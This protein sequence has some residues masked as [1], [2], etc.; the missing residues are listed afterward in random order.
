MSISW[1]FLMVG[2]LIGVIVGSTGV[3]AL[4]QHFV[5]APKKIVVFAG[6]ASA[7]VLEE[8]AEVF[9]TLY[10]IKVEL[11]L[12]GSGSILSAMKIART[13]DLFIPGS[14]EFLIEAAKSGVVNMSTGHPKILVYLVPAIIVQ[15]GNPKNITSLEDLARLGLR[16]GIGDPQSVCVGIYAKELLEKASLWENVSKNIVVY[17]QSC[18]ATAALIPTKAVDAIVGWHVFQ[19]WTPDK[20]DIVWIL[21]RKIPKIGYIAGAVSNFAQDKPSAEAFLD[22]L[23]SKDAQEIWTKYGYFATEEDARVHAP[24]SKIEPL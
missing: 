6:A 7:P 19:S 20:A 12:G 3:F 9:E 10:Q 2:I 14:P 17:A 22:F 5:S 1:K 8:A 13:G 18:D 4:S 24:D 23:A 15:K 11:R 16:L 21:P